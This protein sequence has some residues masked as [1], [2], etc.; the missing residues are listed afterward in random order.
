MTITFGNGKNGMRLPTG[1]ANVIANYRSGIGA[2]GNAD[3]SKVTQ[4]ASRPAGVKTVTNPIPASGGAD[5]DTTEQARQNTASAVFALDRLVSVSDYGDFA[6]TFAGI[7]KATSQSLSDSHRRVVFV[8]MAGSEGTLIDKTSALYTNLIQAFQELGDPHL[9]AEVEICEFMLLVISAQVKVL[10]GYDFDQVAPQIRTAMLDAFGFESQ[11]LAESIPLSRVVATIQN[12]AGVQ[13]VNVQILDSI[14]ESDT[15]PP[16]VLKAKLTEIV[17]AR[18][19]KTII[20]VPPAR[21]DPTT[22]TILPAGLAFLSP[23]L[24]DTLILTEISL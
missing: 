16:E 13:H 15:H 23:D 18:A 8:T 14:S 2:M 20:F 5:G 24:P 11:E 7:G 1:Q 19:P 3:A 12:V 17:T 9:P 10:P 6:R 22:G 21:L 4:L